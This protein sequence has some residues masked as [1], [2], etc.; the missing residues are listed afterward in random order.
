MQILLVEDNAL[1]NHHLTSQ[2]SEDGHIVHAESTASAGLQTIRK[3]PC[4]VAIID[5]G[6]PDFDGLRLIKQIRSG[7]LA[8]PILILTARSSW[9]DKVE[10]LDAGAD[11]YLVKPFQIEELKARLHALVRRSVGFTSP[12]VNAG[13]ISVDLNAKT[14]SVDEQL[15]SLTKFEYS[16]LEH[17]IKNRQKVVSKQ[18]LVDAMYK[19]SQDAQINSIEVII[20]RLRKKLAAVGHDSVISTIRGQ[21]YL[22]E[23]KVG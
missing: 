22:F 20:S 6:L 9:Q 16:I 21:G 7:G 23:L 1:L 18:Q 14:V 10:G 5:I 4:D 8:T 2:L 12:T 17:L 3:Q 11:D 13:N 15:I 19:T